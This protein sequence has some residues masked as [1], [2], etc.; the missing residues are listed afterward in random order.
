MEEEF[1]S[2]S[3]LLAEEV[4]TGSGPDSL[5]FKSCRS[6]GDCRERL[7]C[8]RGVC[9]TWLTTSMRCTDGPSWPSDC[10]SWM[11]LSESLLG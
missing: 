6:S 7:H 2:T 5:H 11:R 10:Q 9:G 3:G 4:H 8:I 1:P